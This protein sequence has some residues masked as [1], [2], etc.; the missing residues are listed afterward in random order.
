MLGGR[1]IVH[2]TGVICHRCCVRRIVLSGF[3]SSLGKRKALQT[4]PAHCGQCLNKVKH[5]ALRQMAYK[6]AEEKV[7]QFFLF[8]PRQNN[9]ANSNS[10]IKVIF[11][12]NLLSPIGPTSLHPAYSHQQGRRPLGWGAACDCIMPWKW[13]ER[14][15]AIRL[16]EDSRINGMNVQHFSFAFESSMMHLIFFSLFFLFPPPP[17]SQIIFLFPLLPPGDLSSILENGSFVFIPFVS[18]SSS[19]FCLGCPHWVIMVTTGL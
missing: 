3:W 13:N 10:D 16:D 14:A 8:V 9:S 7:K 5:R 4:N 2:S 18:P 19:S 17:F 11:S 6:N 1:Q 15:Q 12:R